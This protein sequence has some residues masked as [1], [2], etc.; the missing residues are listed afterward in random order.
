[1]KYVLAILAALTIASPASAFCITAHSGS[2]QRPAVGSLDKS[3]AKLC[4]ERP[5]FP[6]K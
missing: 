1:M 4:G 5:S 6:G 3:G 2:E